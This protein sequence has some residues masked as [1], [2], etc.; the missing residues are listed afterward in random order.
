MSFVERNDYSLAET[1]FDMN[2]TIFQ[3]YEYKPG[4]TTVHSTAYDVYCSR[5]G[6]CQDFTNLFIC[7]CRLLSIP[8]RYRM[9]YIY[10]G[11]DYEN[12]AQGDAS[13]A[14][15]E[16]YLPFLGWRGFDPTNGTVVSQDHIRVACGNYRDA[17][18]TGGTIYKGGGSEILNVDVTVVEVDN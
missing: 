4:A 16:V 2:R 1:L 8:S 11:K 17:T 13:H 10:T 14:W 6:V 7:L 18:P 3:D 5:A 9:G 15:I 12:Q